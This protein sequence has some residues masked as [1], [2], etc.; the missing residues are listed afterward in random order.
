MIESKRVARIATTCETFHLYEHWRQA[1]APRYALYRCYE[2]HVIS[3]QWN[4]K[5]RMQN[6]YL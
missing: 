2:T 4:V 3:M 6:T 5:A 1:G